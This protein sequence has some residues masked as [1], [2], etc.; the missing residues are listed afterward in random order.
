MG[1]PAAVSL[2]FHGGC[3]YVLMWPSQPRTFAACVEGNRKNY[4][5]ALMLAA[6]QSVS[7][8]IR[9]V[10]RRSTHRRS[11]RAASVAAGC[12]AMAAGSWLHGSGRRRRR[13]RTAGH[14][15]Q[16]HHTRRDAASVSSSWTCRNNCSSVTEHRPP[17]AK[18]TVRRRYLFASAARIYTASLWRSV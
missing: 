14:V 1:D 10:P 18:L 3:V 13:R 6:S 15:N 16:S 8:S 12:V 7:Q 2:G 5:L 17:P 4:N 11:V 9:S